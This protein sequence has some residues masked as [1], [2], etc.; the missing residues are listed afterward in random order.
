M[1]LKD[2]CFNKNENEKRVSYDEDRKGLA[3]GLAMDYS[4]FLPGLFSVLRAI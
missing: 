1:C 3:M 4:A 2:I